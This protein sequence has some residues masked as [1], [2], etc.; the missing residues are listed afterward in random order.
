[1]R[2][3]DLS[4]RRGVVVGTVLVM[5]LLSAACGTSLDEDSFAPPEPTVAPTTSAPATTSAAA[6]PATTVSAQVETP[7]AVTTEIVATKDL[8]Y[9]VTGAG[10]TLA[11][12]LYHPQDGESLPLVVVFH[13]NPVFGQTKASV[14]RLSE[15]IAAQGAVVVAPTW[16]SPMAMDMERIA[17]AVVTWNMEHGPCGVW[18]ALDLAS[19]YGADPGR[20]IVVGVTT[21]VLP[22]QSVTF[23]PAV[24]EISGC[25]APP[26]DIS[27][28]R[29]ILFDT[30]WLLV[31][32]IWDE[33]LIHD[34][35]FLS[36]SSYLGALDDPSETEVRML[37]GEHEASDTVRSLGGV[38]YEES[39]W[40]GIR[41][42]EGAWAGDFADLGLL[43]DGEM[44]F[45]DVTRVVTTRMVV[46]GWDAE[47]VIV[48]GAGHSLSSSN[49]IDFVAALVL[50][51]EL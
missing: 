14:Q 2:R 8:P 49:S 24:D 5:G 33:V 25:E 13:G 42:P 44:S 28:D 51:D 3:V 46:A 4:S 23:G 16:G 37:V 35:G 1:M 40:I 15:A 11:L 45:A 32:S 27:V 29:A 38:A 41:D 22:G 20:L 47:L 17:E 21:G 48:P 6:Q 7:Q 12:D 31:P 30:D 26:V 50:A 10:R 9:Y 34:P 36:T 39:D 43:D 18:A 19:S